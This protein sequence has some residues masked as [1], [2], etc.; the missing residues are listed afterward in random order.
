MTTLPAS[1]TARFS[2]FVA[3]A[4]LA[5]STV[6]ATGCAN[7]VDVDGAD[8]TDAPSVDISSEQARMTPPQRRMLGE[9]AGLPNDIVPTVD[10]KNAFGH[11][12]QV[13]EPT[14]PTAKHRVLVDGILVPTDVVAAPREVPR[15]VAKPARREMGEPL[16]VPG[17]FVPVV[18]VVPDYLPGSLVQT[19]AEPT[20]GELEIPPGMPEVDLEVACDRDGRCPSRR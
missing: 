14:P 16:H 4:A 1:L 13:G 7:G 2:S 18:P 20:P 12:R 9:R 3:V 17:G 11:E 15:A 5:F 6:L 8:G 19:E 10:P